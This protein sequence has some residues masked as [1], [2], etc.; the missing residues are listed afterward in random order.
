M[1]KEEFELILKNA[2]DQST[3]SMTEL[4]KEKEKISKTL[5]EI[6]ALL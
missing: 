5:K 4:H 6:R 3:K 2:K 1:T